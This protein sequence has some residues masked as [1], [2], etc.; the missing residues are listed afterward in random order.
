MR[1]LV[2]WL[3]GIK[4][5]DLSG[6]EGLS[7]RLTGI[8]DNLWILLGVLAVFGL[9]GW[10]VVHCYRREGRTPPRVKHALAGTPDRR[11]C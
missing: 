7:L 6:T 3:F 2:T 5:T 8:P 4:Q 1:N 9:L 10:L 11:C